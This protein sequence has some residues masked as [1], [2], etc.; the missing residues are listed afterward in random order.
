MD[1]AKLFLNGRS[2]AVRLPKAFRMPGKIV[3]IHREGRRVILEPVDENWDALEA[4][5]SQFSDDFMEEGREQPS[6]PIP[7]NQAENHP[8]ASTTFAHSVHQ[9][10][11][12][13][14]DCHPR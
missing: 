2:Q 1:T 14:D 12:A 11:A 4:S 5:L 6:M 8:P 3:K 13:D 9:A 10:L 7:P